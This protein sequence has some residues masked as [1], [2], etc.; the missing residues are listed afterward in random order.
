MR[1]DAVPG[2]SDLQHRLPERLFIA[3]SRYRRGGRR[4]RTVRRIAALVLLVAAGAM[5]T[6][7]PSPAAAGTHVLVAARDLATGSILAAGDLRTVA[8]RAP[9]DGALQ[10]DDPPLGQVLAAPVRK[11]EIITDVRLLTG[12]GPLAGPGRS[13]VPV[14]PD[15]PDAVALLRP[16]MRVAAIGVDT[17][18]VAHTLTDDAIVLWVPAPEDASGGAAHGGRLVV[19][20]VPESAADRVAAMAI[21]GAIGIRFT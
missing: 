7:S 6:T 18:G 8:V 16:G 15:D 10:K 19:L 17:D 2:A 21:T 11:G 9:P 4:T 13:A 1:H 14:R 3:L 5:A 12:D 20:S